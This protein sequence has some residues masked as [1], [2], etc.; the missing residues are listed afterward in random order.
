MKDLDRSCAVCKICFATVKYSGNTTN[1]RA[2]VTR[3]HEGATL[4][5]A[6]VSERRVEATQRTIEDLHFSKLPAS[7]AR[8]TKIT[9]SV[10]CFIR[11]DM[12]PLSV[13]ENEGFRN[14]MATLEPRYNIP[15]RQHIT[16]VALPKL[17]MEVKATVLD[18]L[19][20]AERVALTCDTW[21]SRATESYVTLTAH[22]M[23]D[24][25]NLKSHVLQTRAMHDSHTGEH[26]AA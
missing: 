16:D 24:H 1:L 15:S 9:R 18:S 14:M 3:N 10:L 12:R 26:I 2:H 21:T 7:S 8:A 5:Q 4:Q 20:S 11:K 6:N 22:R 17:Y 19:G 23:D 13:V 25:W